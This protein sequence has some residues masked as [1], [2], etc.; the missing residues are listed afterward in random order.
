VKRVGKYMEDKLNS[1]MIWKTWK[2][3]T[4]FN[5]PFFHVFHIFSLFNLLSF[6]IFHIISLFNLLFFHMKRVGK[7]MEDKL[8]SEMIWKTW[9]KRKLKCE[10]I[11]KYRG[12]VS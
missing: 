4:L 10:K 11:G 8:N 6:R 12:N 5:L 9:K 2:K 1:E 7:Y 3:R